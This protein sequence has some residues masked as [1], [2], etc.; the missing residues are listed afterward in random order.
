MIYLTRLNGKKFI[1]NCE[2]IKSV[3][4]TPDTVITL[5]AGEKFM[6]KEKVEEVV[7]ATIVFRRSLCNRISFAPVSKNSS[8]DSSEL[9]EQ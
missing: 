7:E 3:E 6:V 9:N 4:A 2:L 1:L 8:T 5:A